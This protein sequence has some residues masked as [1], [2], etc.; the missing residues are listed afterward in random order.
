MGMDRLDRLAQLALSLVAARWM[1]CCDD[2]GDP[3]LEVFRLS[4]RQPTEL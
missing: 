1:S 2:M 3:R 4:P